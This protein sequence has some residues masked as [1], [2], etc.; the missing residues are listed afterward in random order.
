MIIELSDKYSLMISQDSKNDNSR[1]ADVT[2]GVELNNGFEKRFC[3]SVFKDQKYLPDHSPNAFSLTNG[4]IGV[5]KHDSELYHWKITTGKNN[6]T[7]VHSIL[8]LYKKGNLKLCFDKKY[9]E[10]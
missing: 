5:T 1:N 6:N 8:K 10:T 2:Y 3:K 4:R 9:L 7:G